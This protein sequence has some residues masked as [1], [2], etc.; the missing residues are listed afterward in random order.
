M[1]KSKNELRVTDDS[2]ARG[3]SADRRTVFVGPWYGAV[4]S[5]PLAM[6]VNHKSHK[7][8]GTDYA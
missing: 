5:A 4:V 6:P 7:L 3:V 1:R 8:L 2:M